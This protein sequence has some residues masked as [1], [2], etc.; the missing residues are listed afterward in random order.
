MDNIFIAGLLAARHRI[1]SD[2][3]KSCDCRRVIINVLN[4][5]SGMKGWATINYGWESLKFYDKW[6]HNKNDAKDCA[7]ATLD[8]I[9]TQTKYSDAFLKHFKEVILTKDY[10]ESLKKHYTLFK[11]EIEKKGGKKKDDVASMLYSKIPPK[12][13]Y[14]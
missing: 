9:N 13:K 14:N 8:P 3:Q 6:I 11:T 12:N 10:K 4:K 2:R 5:D 7:S 1:I